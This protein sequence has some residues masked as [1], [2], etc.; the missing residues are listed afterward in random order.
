[1]ASPQVCG[2]GALLLQINPA[3]KPVEFKNYL[4]QNTGVALCHFNEN[5]DYTVSNSLWGGLPR[6]LFNKFNS[7]TSLTI[8]TT[9]PA[10]FEGIC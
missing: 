5:N 9:E 8:K 4:L 7:D 3:A 6:V 2:L 10:P 1:M